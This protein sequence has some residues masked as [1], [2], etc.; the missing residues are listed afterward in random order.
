[1]TRNSPTL[2]HKRDLFSAGLVE[3]PCGP[4]DF[5]ERRR[6]Y[7]QYVR[8]WSNAGKVVKVTHELP[9]ELF[10]QRYYTTLHGGNIFASHKPYENN[11]HFFWI[12]PATSRKPLEWWSIPPFPFFIKAFAV[13]L[14]DGILAVAE[15]KEG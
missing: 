1:M 7:E 6:L 5:S 14:T 12:P 11:I 10:I 3:N 9:E 2:R 15:E 8:K 4:R 13:Y